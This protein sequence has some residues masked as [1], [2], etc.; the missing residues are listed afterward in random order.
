MTDRTQPNDH[1][2]TLR[3]LDDAQ[4]SLGPFAHDLE[5]LHRLATLGTLTA[6]VAHEINNMLTPALAYAELAQAHPDDAALVAKALTKASSG[7]QAA[8][9]IAESILGFSSSGG[10]GGHEQDVDA[11]VRRSLDCLARTPDKIGI[12]V[13]VNTPPGLR[14][15]ISGLSLQHVLVNLILNACEALRQKGGKL[16]I[17]ASPGGPG[18]V[19]LSVA[20]TGPGISPDIARRLFEPFF[21]SRTEDTPGDSVA[22]DRRGGSGLGLAICKHLV[23]QAGGRIEFETSLGQGT[24]FTLTLPERRVPH[25]KAG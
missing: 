13:V 21:T 25:A 23:E 14:T 8:T 2:L 9:R 3:R 4:A 10:E 7:I 6:G 15:Q 11:I 19:S 20:D 24:T 18:E 16:F 12:E 17:S 22:P 5:H 1:S